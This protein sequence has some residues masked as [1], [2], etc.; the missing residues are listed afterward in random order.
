MLTQV[1]SETVF[2]GY[3]PPIASKRSYRFWQAFYP[4]R[5]P[6]N[7]IM[8][9]TR[10]SPYPCYGA[11]RGALALKRS[12]YCNDRVNAQKVME[13]RGDR[14]NKPEKQVKVKEWGACRSGRW[15]LQNR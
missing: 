2:A 10:A 4:T 14:E 5:K 7:A 6:E 11:A 13:N 12:G 3:L 1:A 15:P 8:F 9:I